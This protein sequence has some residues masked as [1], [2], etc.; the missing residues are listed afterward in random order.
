MNSGNG[1][2]LLYKEECY[3]IQGAVFEVYRVL[4]CGFSESVY[5]AALGK[6]FNLRKIPYKSQPEILVSYKGELLEQSF[7]PDFI[8][9]GKIVL[10]LKATKETLEEH[11]AQILNYL[12]IVNFKLGLLINFGHYPR[13]SV[14]RIIL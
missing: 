9:F 4:G 3:Q 11:K 12:K 7:K 10:E 8:C 2:Q 6:E 14:E 1:F 13:V 5:Q